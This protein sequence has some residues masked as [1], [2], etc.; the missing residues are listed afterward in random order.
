[1]PRYTTMQQR[2]SSCKYCAETGF[3][4]TGR[5]LI[6]L[7][8]SESLGA[9]KIGVAGASSKN[10]RLAK[11]KSRGW[12][13][14]KTKEFNKGE[15]AFSVEQ[16]VL[17]WLRVEKNLQA[18]VNASDMPQGGSSETVDA[19]EIEVLTIWRKVLQFSKV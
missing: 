16:R 1:M 11:H 12:R 9:H 6:Y 13:I 3:D 18:W 17:Y 10:E 7:I 19:A 15:Q 8:T 14:V 2:G 5:A 4:F